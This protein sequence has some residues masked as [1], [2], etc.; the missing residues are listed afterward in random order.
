MYKMD[1]TENNDKPCN[2]CEFTGTEDTIFAVNK[3]DY[4]LV[5]VCYY[6]GGSMH[7]GCVI[8]WAEEYMS[9]SGSDI[10]LGEIYSPYTEYSCSRCTCKFYIDIVNLRTK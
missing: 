10:W 6:C 9:Q 1:Q 8:S 4:E 7:L 5:N 2:C 3:G